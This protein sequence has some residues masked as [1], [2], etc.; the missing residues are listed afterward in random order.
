ML[1]ESWLVL[2]SKFLQDTRTA[3]ASHHG[4]PTPASRP[5]RNASHSINQIKSNETQSAHC[6]LLLKYNTVCEWSAHNT[7]RQP[8]G[9]WRRHPTTQGSDT[10]TV[11]QNDNNNNNNDD[12]GSNSNTATANS[13]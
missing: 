12:D 10:A 13:G 5:Q 4:T 9:T 8:T 3:F 7:T 6:M 2:K 11:A 1:P